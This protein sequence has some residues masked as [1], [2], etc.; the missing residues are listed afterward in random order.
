MSEKFPDI[1]PDIE[2]RFE[3]ILE[4]WR[5]EKQNSVKNRIMKYIN[6]YLDITTYLKDHA[7]DRI[8]VSTLISYLSSMLQD[9]DKEFLFP[10]IDPKNKFQ[11]PPTWNRGFKDDKDE[12]DDSWKY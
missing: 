4:M 9:F 3:E 2:E 6:Y 5:V 10:K 7:R 1:P 8:T 12:E 11:I